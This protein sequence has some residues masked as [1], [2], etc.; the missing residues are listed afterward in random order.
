MSNNTKKAK[1]LSFL[2][3]SR[4]IILVSLLLIAMGYLLM[5]GPGSTEQTFNPDIFSPQRI[6]VAPMLCLAGYL[7]VVVGILRWK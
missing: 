4:F 5:Y 3:T 7:L 2:T 1:W 6:V